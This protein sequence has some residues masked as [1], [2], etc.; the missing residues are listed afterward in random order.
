LIECVTRGWQAFKSDWVNK[1]LLVNKF[2][3]A[4]VTTPPPPNQ[5]AALRKIEEDSKRAAKPNAEVQAKIA[6]LLKGRA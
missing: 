6:E 2:D 1:S 4:H 5:D 3:V